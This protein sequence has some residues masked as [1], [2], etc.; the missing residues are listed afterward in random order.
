MTWP[1]ENPP[2][3][4]RTLPISSCF[5]E[6]KE[7]VSDADYEPLSVTKNGVVPRLD[8]VALTNA[9]DNRKLVRRG[10]FVINS[11]SDRK[12]SS[13]ISSLDGS[14]SVVYTV[15]TPRSVI[16]GRYAHHVLRSTA[17]QE[18][19][20]RWGSGIVADLWSTRYSAMKSISIPF[21]P[22]PEQEAIANYL[23]RETAQIDT[24]IAKQAQLIATL[25]ERRTSQ[26]STTALDG[27]SPLNTSA[28]SGPT[29]GTVFE[30]TL[31][32]M[33]DA[34][35]E[36]SATDTR[37]PYIRAANLQDEGL[38]LS[39]VNHMWYS[40]AEI[41]RLNIKAKDL[42]VVE[43]GAV[44]TSVLVAEDMPGWSFQKTVNRIRARDDWSTAWLG[45]VL[46]AY[47]DE[48]IIDLICD[49][50]T[51][52]HLTAEKLRALRLPS[53]SIAEQ[54]QRATALDQVTA[55]IDTLIAKAE[56][57]IEL[58]KERRAALITAAVTGQLDIPTDA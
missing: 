6:R 36:P 43:G 46:R 32:K 33:L 49:G 54:I 50:S 1:F 17:F 38:R 14:V 39:D 53:I 9:T 5:E 23:D 19:F 21:P 55:H 4:W 12:G 8:N 2:S 31:G 10:D 58:S 7:T 22:L 20:Y 51:I 56:R 26:I 15:L 27:F 13:G 18:E 24:L 11:R 3:T 44:G 41:A 29:L 25:R 57:F 42:L 52:A 34:K 45:Y 30:V 48:G 28:S 40:P 16:S 35:K 47:R 37:L